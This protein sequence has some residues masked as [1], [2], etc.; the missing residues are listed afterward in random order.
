[1][2]KLSD[3]ILANKA[4]SVATPASMSASS[5][6]HARGSGDASGHLS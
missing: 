5:V 4:L 1:M 3:A 6:T 2:T